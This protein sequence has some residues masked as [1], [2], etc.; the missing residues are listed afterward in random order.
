MAAK[1]Q[2][3]GKE[4][5]QTN[6]PLYTKLFHYHVIIMLWVRKPTTEALR[7][8][9]CS[10]PRM[11]QKCFLILNLAFYERLTKKRSLDKYL[12]P[13]FQRWNTA[14]KNDQILSTSPLIMWRIMNPSHEMW[15]SS[16]IAAR[17]PL[18]ASAT[19]TSPHRAVCS[20]KFVICAVTLSA[21][22]LP[23]SV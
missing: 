6:K 8:Q 21:Q 16:S 11:P 13:L 1:T 7:N 18:R 22:Q 2:E 19:H 23:T 9:I 20:M 10:V 12:F 14:L 5:K 3:R 17:R 4:K 15:Q